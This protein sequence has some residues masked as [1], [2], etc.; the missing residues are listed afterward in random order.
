MRTIYVDADACPVKA[1][2]Y[3][4]A[5][6][7]DFRVVVVANMSMRVPIGPPVVELVVR[8]D[9]GAVDDFIADTIKPGDIAITADLPLAGRCLTAGGRVVDPRGRRIT[10]N[11]I[12]QLLGTRDLMET[13]RQ[14]G[15]VTGGPPPMAAKDR[16]RFLATLDQVINEVRRSY[17][18]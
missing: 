12:G 11:E 17:P 8:S 6:R 4:V 9:F 5:A 15:Q 2:V 10:D 13:L 18:M 16:S 1:E 7:Y 3:R 14:T